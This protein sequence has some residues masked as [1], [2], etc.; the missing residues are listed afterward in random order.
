MKKTGLFLMVVAIGFLA[1]CSKSSLEAASAPSQSGAMQVDYKKICQ[2]LVPLAAAEKRGSFAA[3]CEASYR[4][5][6]PS[7]S[8]ATAV[9]DCFTNIKSWDER[10]GC[11]DSCKRDTPR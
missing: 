9:N 1:A 4:S 11:L 5:Y 6:L 7:C 3:T 2:H 10:L 8:N